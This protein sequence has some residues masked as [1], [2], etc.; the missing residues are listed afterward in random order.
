MVL[1]R[2]QPLVAEVLQVVGVSDL[3][4]V[5]DDEQAALDALKSEGHARA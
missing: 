4:P 2:P 3:I 5:F 1:V